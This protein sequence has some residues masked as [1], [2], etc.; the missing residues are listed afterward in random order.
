MLPF[1]RLFLTV[2][3]AVECGMLNS[4]IFAQIG[5]SKYEPEHYGFQRFIEKSQYDQYFQNAEL[6]IAH[7]GI[8]VITQALNS[9][10]P[11]LVMA[12]K[13]KLGEHVNDHQVSTARRFEELGHVLSFDESNMETKFEEIKAFVPKDRMPNIEGVRKRVVEFLIEVQRRP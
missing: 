12:R 5:E 13:A 1:D 2:D 9:K 7:A 8:G 11:L 4:E 3:H 10:T 6:V